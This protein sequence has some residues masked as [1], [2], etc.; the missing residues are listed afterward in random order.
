MTRT[1]SGLDSRNME[2]SLSKKEETYRSFVYQGKTF[3]ARPTGGMISGHGGIPASRIFETRHG[4]SYVL[5]PL[6]GGLSPRV[7]DFE[8]AD[9]KLISEI[10]MA[11]GRKRKR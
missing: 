11:I 3:W 10:A 9:R 5:V 6:E 2:P 8:T 1:I 7:V 4:D